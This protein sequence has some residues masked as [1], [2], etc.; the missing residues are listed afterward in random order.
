MDAYFGGLAYLCSSSLLMMKN[1]TIDS[2][3]VEENGGILYLKTN[4][5]VQ[6]DNCTITNLTGIFKGGIIFAIN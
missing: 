2:V 6:I 4:N 5:T 1:I 3:N